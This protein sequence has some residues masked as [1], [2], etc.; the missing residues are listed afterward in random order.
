MADQYDPNQL[1]PMQVPGNDWSSMASAIIP[2]IIGLIAGRGNP[3]AG[4]AGASAG[5]GGILDDRERAIQYNNQLI[6]KKQVADQEKERTALEKQH[7]DTLNNTAVEA[8]N[9]HKAQAAKIQRDTQEATQDLESFQKWAGKLNDGPI[10]EAAMADLTKSGRDKFMTWY[11]DNELTDTATLPSAKASL[12]AA[13]L[14]PEQV[15]TFAGSMPPKKLAALAADIMKAKA[16]HQPIRLPNP[17]GNSDTILYPDG[18]TRNFPHAPNPGPAAAQPDKGLTTTQSMQLDAAAR[19]YWE[20]SQPA[21]KR[22]DLLM[23][24]QE[25]KEQLY[26]QWVDGPGGQAFISGKIGNV[27]KKPSELSG[28]GAPTPRA[29]KILDDANTQRILKEAGG[30]PKKAA[31]IAKRQGFQLPGR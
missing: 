31:A 11:R 2:G 15:E 1:T 9:L 5:A 28:G 23:M 29:G 7:Y 18:S 26:Q 13:G 20:A 17:Y 14:S 6:F 4:I 21:D 27:G 25:Q 16:G 24:P 10:K 3:V 8:M 22:V 30:D 12:Q 19:K